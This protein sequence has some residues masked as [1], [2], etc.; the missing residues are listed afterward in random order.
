MYICVLGDEFDQVFEDDFLSNIDPD[1]FLA[2]PDEFLATI[3]PSLFIDNPTECDLDIS[4]I[5]LFV[6]MIR[7]TELDILFED[8]SDVILNDISEEPSVGVQDMLQFEHITAFC[9]YFEYFYRPW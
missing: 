2:D 3:D 7:K 5:D 4:D 9:E 6:A 1:V 8:I